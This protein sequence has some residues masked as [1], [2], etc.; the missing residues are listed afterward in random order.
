MSITYLTTFLELKD[1]EGIQLFQNSVRG[2]LNTLPEENTITKEGK[3]YKF[4]PFIYQ[5]AAKTKS[6][7]N[8]EAQIILANNSVAMNHVKRAFDKKANIVV[9]VCK[10]NKDF[11]FKSSD[12]ILTTEHWILASFAYDATTIEVLLSSS[13]DAVGTTAPNRVFSEN[14]V[15]FLPRTGNI[16]TL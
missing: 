9:Q 8:L 11:E 5:G 14:I 13:I 3:T 10:M 2:P 1:S 6:G 16:Q 15:G 4:L 7:D 12:Q